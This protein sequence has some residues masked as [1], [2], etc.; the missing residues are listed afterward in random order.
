[1]SMSPAE[2]RRMMAASSVSGVSPSSRAMRRSGNRFVNSSLYGVAYNYSRNKSERT[3]EFDTVDI[4][5][6]GPD[7]SI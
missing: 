6:E 3:L 2:K 4:S 5:C 1:M 7:D